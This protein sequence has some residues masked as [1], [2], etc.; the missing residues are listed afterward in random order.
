[1]K[2][3]ELTMQCYNALHSRI[4]QDVPR[5]LSEERNFSFFFFFFQVT[6]QQIEVETE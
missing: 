6:V 5:G 4:I 2:L 3:A 1:M